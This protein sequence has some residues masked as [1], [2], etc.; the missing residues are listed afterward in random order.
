MKG[1]ILVSNHMTLSDGQ[2]FCGCINHPVSQENGF[3]IVWIHI[4]LVLTQRFCVVL[5]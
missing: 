2:A 4:C 1:L 3:V 5:V